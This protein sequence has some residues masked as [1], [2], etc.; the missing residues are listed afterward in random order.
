MFLPAVDWVESG[1]MIQLL[2]YDLV[3]VFFEL[4]CKSFECVIRP[5]VTTQLTGC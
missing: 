4:A 5:E 3:T 1:T 2:A